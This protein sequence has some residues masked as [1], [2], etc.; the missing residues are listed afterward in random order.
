MWKEVMG[1]TV[2]Q[3]RDKANPDWSLRGEGDNY[4]IYY[5]SW[6]EV[7]EFIKKLN[8]RYPGHHYRLPTEAEWEYA[9][10]AGTTTRFHTG[11]S[12]S[13]LGRAV[14]YRDNSGGK[15]HP[16]GQKR[17]NAWGLY[18]MHGNVWEWCEDV[19]HNN[20]G[21]APDDGSAWTR[22]GDVRRVLRGGSW[23]FIT[24]YCRSANRGRSHPDS[25][26]DNL[27]FRLV[28]FGG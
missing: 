24:R 6:K 4:P 27:G 26:H 23:Y 9:C 17:A 7:Q 13:D 28:C 25:R 19:W 16:V 11:D 21:G 20:Y 15:T 1:M 18:D 14:W 8:R 3:Q 5:V 10:R 2:R 22:G 12:E